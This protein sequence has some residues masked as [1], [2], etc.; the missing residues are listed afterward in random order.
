M[1]PEAVLRR[2]GL[3]PALFLEEKCFLTTE[4]LFAFWRAVADLSGDPAIGL[5]LGS[6]DRVERLDLVALAALSASS[7]RDAVARAARYKQLCCPEE[8]HVKIRGGECAV[9]FRWLLAEDVEPWALTDLCFAWIA[10]LAARGTGGAVRP[11]RVELKRAARNRQLYE[12]HFGCRVRF[13]AP[14]NALIFRASDLDRPFLTHNADLLGILAP[15][16]DAELADRNARQDAHEQVRGALRRLLASGRPGLRSVARELGSSARTLQRRLG[17]LGVSY[18]QVL[19]EARRDMATQYLMQPAL[20]LS[21]I[22]YLLG[23]EDANSFFRAFRRWEGVSPGRWRDGQRS[24]STRAL[25][26]GGRRQAS[27]IEQRVEPCRTVSARSTR[28][29]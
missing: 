19:E 29:G 23:Y 17:H 9:R 10:T 26:L 24:R 8:I 28:A 16:L 5:A 14:D 13:N 6:E 15:Q 18:Q 27:A 3:P 1:S 21:D 22:A 25:P 2:A 11:H 4:Q 20:E 7:F 12:S